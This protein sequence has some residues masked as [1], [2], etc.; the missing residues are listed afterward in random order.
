MNTALTLRQKGLLVVA[1]LLGFE[2][3][4]LGGLNW[5]LSDAEKQIARHQRAQAVIASLQRLSS[6]RERAN[7]GVLI[8]QFFKDKP[9]SARFHETF[10]KHLDAIPQQ[11]DKIRELIKDDANGSKKLAELDRYTRLGVSLI[12]QQRQFYIAQNTFEERMTT[13]RLAGILFQTSHWTE[14]LLEDYEKIE[15]EVSPLEEESRKRLAQALWVMAAINIV[16]AVVI[17]QM[18]VKSIVSRLSIITANSNSLASGAKLNAPLEG[19]DEI[20]ELDHVFHNMAKRLAESAQMKQE[21]VQ[22]ISHDLRTPL[23]AILGTF[24]LLNSGAYGDLSERGH[25]RVGDA[26]NESQRLIAMINE[27]LDI[28]RLESG[29][30]QLMREELDLQPILKRSIEAVSVIA[31]ARQIKFVAGSE[32]PTV[33]VDGDRIVQLLINLLGNAV[34][35]SPEGGVIS[36]NVSEQDQ[37]VRIEVV[38]QGPGIPKHEQNSIFERFKQIESSEYKRSGSSGLGLAICKALVESHGGRIGVN[39]EEGKGSCFWFTVPKSI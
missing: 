3:L 29:N 7:S 11:L 34:K 26:V 12:E 36:V 2:L 23:T 25:S 24:E 38:D 30:M 16:I 14:S 32:N 39:S 4:L 21:F 9:D 17:G 18:F 28:E 13:A 22:M 19:S 27:L 10:Q 31:S 5:L 20:V 6:L 1:S 33:T 15:R 8:Q 35:Y 37:L